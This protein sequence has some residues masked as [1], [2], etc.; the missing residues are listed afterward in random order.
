MNDDPRSDGLPSALIA[1][2][3][4]AP[5]PRRELVERPRL[6]DR[7]EL[8]SLPPLTIVSAPAGFGKTTL[9]A[10][11]FARTRST[12]GRVTWLSLDARDNDPA[13]FLSYLLAALAAVDD[14]IGSNALDLLRSAEPTQ[15][16]VASLLNDLA[17]SPDDIAIVLDDHHVIHSPE[18]HD[19][20]GFL[21][22]H[23]P[24]QVHLVIAGRSDPP[25]PLGR[26]RA[27]GD[28]LEV[29]AADLRFTDGEA[30][31]YLNDSMGLRSRRGRRDHA[32]DPHRGMDRGPA[33]RRA[34]DAGTRR[35]LRVHRHLRRRRPLRRRLPRR[36][37]ARAPARRDPLVP[38]RDVGPRS[39]HRRG[40]RRGD[41]SHR[42]RRHDRTARPGEPLPGP[43]RRPPP[44]VPVPPPLRRRAQGPAPRRGPGVD[45]RA[46]PAGEQVVRAGGRRR[47]RGHARPR[48]RGP[49]ASRRPHRGGRT[50]PPPEPSGPD[51][52]DV[53]GGAPR[54]R[55]RRPARARHGPRGVPGDHP[56]PDRGRRPA[57]AGGDLA[58][59]TRRRA[60]VVV[61]HD[62]FERLP[63]EVLVHRVGLTHAGRRLR[64]H[65]PV[66]H[67]GPRAGA[68]RRR[69]APRR[70]QRPARDRPLGLR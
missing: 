32:R 57:R 40:V 18:V 37:G 59:R 35:S 9:L 14:R 49:R 56:R 10:D 66:G 13:M 38:A 3:L 53:A 15:T 41:R 30:A 28:L 52:E 67:P 70:G 33:A 45:A 17:A 36:G 20:L 47:V 48:R 39:V 7:L 22:D 50:P 5:A 16:V 25:L 23:L 27:R 55:V 24:R 64:R 62:A 4:H 54:G 51:P 69:T 63:A 34:L 19:A 12:G 43:A 2:K 58:R 42:R 61:D 31:A 46:P 26:L 44:L 1:T 8:P 21:V 68:T 65:R 11:W 6:V 60:P 29:R